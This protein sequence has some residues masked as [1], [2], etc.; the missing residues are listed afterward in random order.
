MIKGIF[1]LKFN[2]NSVNYTQTSR[3]EDIELDVAREV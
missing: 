2:F 3:I 1:N